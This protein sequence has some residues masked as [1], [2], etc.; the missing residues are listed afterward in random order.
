ML[1]VP[2]LDSETV[3]TKLVSRPGR[4]QGLLY[5]QPCDWLINWVSHPFPP[6]A[7]RRRHAQTVRDRASSYKIDYVI[8]IKKFLNPK[9]HQNP[10][11]GSKVTAILLKRWIWPIGGASVGE[12]W[13]CSLRSRLVFRGFNPPS[14]GPK[15]VLN[16]CFVCYQD[17]SEFVGFSHNL[18]GFVVNQRSISAHKLTFNPL[19]RPYQIWYPLPNVPQKYPCLDIGI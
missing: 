15:Y 12:G 13:P 7:L 9:G 5:K 8:V 2:S 6:I 1:R 17:L 19:R 10:F 4:S 18:L 14:A 16:D 3:S 11:S